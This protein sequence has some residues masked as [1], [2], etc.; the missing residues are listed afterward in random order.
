MMY[1]II[2]QEIK[3]AQIAA[4]P[5]DYLNFYCLG[6]R[7]QCVED[8]ATANGQISSNGNTVTVPHF[9]VLY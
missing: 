9:D 3:A 7:E 8:E 4:H 6:N 2:A 1:D 5:T